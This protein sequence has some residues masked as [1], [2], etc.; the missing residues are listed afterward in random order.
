MHLKRLLMFRPQA[1][2]AHC[3][4]VARYNFVQLLSTSCTQSTMTYTDKATTET[5]THA[6]LNVATHCLSYLNIRASPFH[7]RCMRQSHHTCVHWQ[8]HSVTI[9][10]TCSPFSPVLGEVVLCPATLGLVIQL[11]QGAGQVQVQGV[12][13][14]NTEFTF[15]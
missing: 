13:R 14:C 8:C 2:Q 6:F 5:H 10:S 9:L 7:P 4:P 3:K 12:S 15:T 11:Q 1:L